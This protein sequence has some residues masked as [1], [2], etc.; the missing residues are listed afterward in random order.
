[1]VNSEWL[2]AKFYFFLNFIPIPTITTN[3]ARTVIIPKP[4]PISKIPVIG[5]Q[6]LKNRIIRNKINEERSFE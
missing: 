4:I 2:N 6:E 5:L 1:M 3:I